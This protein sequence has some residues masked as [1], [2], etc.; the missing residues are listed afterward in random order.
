[1]P[2][3]YGYDASPFKE[4]LSSRPWGGTGWKRS[5]YEQAQS[6]SGLTNVFCNGASGHGRNAA[7][8]LPDDI[9]AS[10][11][12]RSPRRDPAG[13]R[14]ADQILFCGIATPISIRRVTGGAAAHP[15][16][17]SIP[18]HE[19]VGRVAGRLDDLPSISPGDLAAV[20]CMDLTRTEPPHCK[21][22][23]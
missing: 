12:S 3:D 15:G 19:I 1:V 2:G 10:T 7:C 4:R 13:A 6:G 9:A 23:T 18:S 14:C 21:R 20:G 22:R 8:Q 11:E 5:A 17:P 16:L